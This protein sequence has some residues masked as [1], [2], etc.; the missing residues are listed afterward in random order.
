MPSP[1]PR[2]K[3][4]HSYDESPRSVSDALRATRACGLCKGAPQQGR[5]TEAT[6]TGS[7]MGTGRREQNNKQHAR[8]H[9]QAKLKTRS[10]RRGHK[11]TIPQHNYHSA[12][13]YS[14]A[15]AAQG[16]TQQNF[17]G[18]ITSHFAAPSLHISRVHD[19]KISRYHHVSHRRDRQRV[20]AVRA[21][22][23][24]GAERAPPAAGRLQ[25]LEQARAVERAAA[26]RV[27]ARV[28]GR[29]A[30]LCECVA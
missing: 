27:A 4:K 6:S 12:R 5:P 16:R 11:S 1:F 29:V 2:M 17:R 30:E 20:R 15:R 23:K 25:P 13:T 22:A 19:F 18:T 24:H 26:A 28:V 8:T 21:R 9:M 14:G 3:Q 10:Q 7:S